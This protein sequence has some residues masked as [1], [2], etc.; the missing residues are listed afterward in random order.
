MDDFEA[1]TGAMLGTLLLEPLVMGA[2]GMIFVDPLFQ[3][4]LIQVPLHG[5][6]R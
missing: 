3:K 1:D 6:V 2:G 5:Q 4:M